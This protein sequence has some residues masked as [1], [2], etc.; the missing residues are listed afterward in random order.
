M[1][2]LHFGTSLFLVEAAT[3][4]IVEGV[5]NENGGNSLQGK[6]EPNTGKNLQL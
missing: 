4:R 6:A 2:Y 5:A 1:L 3:T